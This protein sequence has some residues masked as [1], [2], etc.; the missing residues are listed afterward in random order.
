[1]ALSDSGGQPREMQELL[2]FEGP[3]GIPD[4]NI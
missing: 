3:L 1:M 4:Y 2:L